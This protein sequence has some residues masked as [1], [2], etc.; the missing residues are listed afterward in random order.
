MEK[1]VLKKI[2]AVS[3]TGVMACAMLVGCGNSANETVSS[4]NGEK[5]YK[6]GIFQ[7]QQH[8]ALDQAND[9]FIKALEESGIDYSVDQ[10]NASGDQS[11]AKTIAEKMVND[12]DDLIFTIATPAAQATA[13]LT[14]EIPI[15][16]TAV[17]DPADAGLVKSNDAPGGN[18]TGTSDLNP[19]EKQITLLK[20]LIPDAKTVG[21]LYCSAEANSKLQ[22]N[23]VKEVCEQNGLEAK[24]F[25]VSNSN[26]IQTVVESMVNKVD[27]IYAPTDNV[28]SNAMATVAMVAN[29]NKLPIIAGEE[30]QVEAGALA[31]Y[32]VN[33]E[34]LG[35]KAGEM[36][37]QILKGE[38]K[39]GEIPI[40]Y[41]NDD[42]YKLSINEETAKTLGIDTSVVQK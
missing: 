8:P 40:G 39:A 19:V 42:E 33:Y 5:G 14:T 20:Q 11:T 38:K 26:E 23:L 4:G 32:S 10:Q 25:T 9:G 3:M 37:V 34:T 2:M 1:N 22:A 41:L 18:V 36:A 27:V 6:I 12:K 16:L 7:Y 24:D 21:I 13:G 28:I 15:V 31:T 29:E 30:N 35:Y 17:T